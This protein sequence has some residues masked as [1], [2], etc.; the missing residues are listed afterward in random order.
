MRVDNRIAFITGA[1][2]GLGKAF[3][4][5]LAEAGADVVISELP[6]R[7]DAAEGVA[8]VIRQL[9]RRA[10]TLSLDVRD[11]E[12]IEAAVESIERDLGPIDIA[13][14]NAGINITQPT[15]EVTEEAWDR[16]LDTN[17]KGVFF[18]AQRV[19]R[20]MAVRERGKIINIASQNGLVGYRDRAS[21]CSAKG[22][23]VNL[24]RLLAIELA[25]F[26]IQVNAVAPTFVFTPLTGPM[27]EDDGFREDVLSRIPLGRI[28]VPEEI[29]GSVVFLASAAADMITGHTLV[30]DGG[31]TAQ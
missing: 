19:A 17:L 21:Y 4:M 3:A 11:V 14:T 5:A 18:T 8:D 25:A 24:T 20:R 23:V 7:E 13:V 6:G 22:G 16:V 28:A 10:L 9:G 15:L 27:F 12:M 2:S 30:V 1:G 26:N 31:W 29:V